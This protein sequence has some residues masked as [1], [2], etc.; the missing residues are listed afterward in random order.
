MAKSK[1]STRLSFFGSSPQKTHQCEPTNEV[2][3]Y[4]RRNEA[5]QEDQSSASEFSTDV[6]ERREGEAVINQLSKELELQKSVIKA[7]EQEMMKWQLIFATQRENIDKDV[8][9]WQAALADATKANQEKHDEDVKKV[10]RVLADATTMTKEKYE[11]A[12]K[13]WQNSFDEA[14]TTTQF[15]KVREAWHRLEASR[16]A[17]TTEMEQASKR[18]QHL[19]ELATLP[20]KAMMEAKQMIE[21]LEQQRDMSTKNLA[22][23]TK[24]EIKYV[25]D[26]MKWQDTLANATAKHKEDCEKW[27]EAFYDSQGSKEMKQVHNM[28]RRLLATREV[29]TEEMEKA[30]KMLEQLE[31]EKD[32]H[33]IVMKH[34]GSTIYKLEKELLSLKGEIKSTKK[35]IR[36]AEESID[37]LS[38][39]CGTF[40]DHQEEGAMHSWLRDT[41]DVL[42]SWLCGT[43][44][45]DEQSFM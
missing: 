15:K 32:A 20:S 30:I 43:G 36:K 25:K 5:R 24:K 18:L 27:E 41:G 3:N 44:D 33:T 31:Q 13:Q 21:Q 42:D 38:D 6:V 9:K 29:P 28:M 8:K 14:S 17:P 16:H 22:L 4:T 1:P 7:K 45:G 23:T 10:Q 37:D 35:L 39:D 2:G 19:E 40:F 12:L 11:E 26:V 34:A